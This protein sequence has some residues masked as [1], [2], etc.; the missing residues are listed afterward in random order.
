MHFSLTEIFLHYSRL[1]DLSRNKLSTLVDK[2]FDGLYSLREI[3]LDDNEIKSMV[4]A[5]FRHVT[6]LETLSLSNNKL[7]GET[8]HMSTLRPRG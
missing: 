1:L 8:L 2:N 3:F 5:A 6:Q 7:E 4:S